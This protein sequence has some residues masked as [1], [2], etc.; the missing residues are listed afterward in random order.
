LLLSRSLPCTGRGAERPRGLG[1][2]VADEVHRIESRHVLRLQEIDRMAFALA[3]QGDEHIGPRHLILARGLDMDGGALDHALESRRRLGIARPVGGE[4]GEVLIK[5]FR[6][7]GAQLVQIDAAGAQ[8]G[9][10]VAVVGQAE[11]KML[12]RSVFVPAIAC[13]GEGTVERLFEIAGQHGRHSSEP[14]A[15]TISRVWSGIVPAISRPRTCNFTLK[16]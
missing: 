11:Q 10:G 9:G 13:E 15:W 6:E 5:E 8:H 2:A 4:A 12:E 16:T 3:E 1:D 7:I 14:T